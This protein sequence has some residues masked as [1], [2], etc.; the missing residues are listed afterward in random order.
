[1]MG[2]ML[3]PPGVIGSI[4]RINARSQKSAWD[5]ARA[6]QVSA[7]SIPCLDPFPITVTQLAADLPLKL[8]TSWG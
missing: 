7:V 4:R 2:M 8:Q 3:L 6:K 5:R 1:M